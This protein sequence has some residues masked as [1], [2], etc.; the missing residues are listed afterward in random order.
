M[1]K[2]GQ[3]LKGLGNPDRLL[4]GLQRTGAG[5]GV[6]MDPVTQSRKKEENM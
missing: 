1:Q 2:T 3:G 6:E 4:P 5:L